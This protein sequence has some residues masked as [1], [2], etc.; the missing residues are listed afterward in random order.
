MGNVT[1][2]VI[3]V[4]EMGFWKKCAR[5]SLKLQFYSLKIPVIEANKDLQPFSPT[6]PKQSRNYELLSVRQHQNYLY[7]DPILG[8]LFR[9]VK[10]EMSLSISQRRFSLKFNRSWLKWASVLFK[11]FYKF[12]RSLSIIA[13]MCIFAPYKTISSPYFPFPCAILRITLSFFNPYHSMRINNKG[14]PS[15][16]DGAQ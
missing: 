3:F 1:R 5:G 16:T 10:S 9:L 8:T 11:S 15:N 14:I 6:T 4:L 12:L 7:R 13:Y 2:K